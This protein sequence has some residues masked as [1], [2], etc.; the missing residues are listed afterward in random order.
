MEKV[1]LYLFGAPHI[2]ADG[3][4]VKISRRKALALL[5]Y[6]AAN[7]RAHSRESLAA[8]L[9]PEWDTASARTALRRVLV[10]AHKAVGPDALRVEQDRISLPAEAGLW[11]DVRRF[12]AAL[13]QSRA[14][15]HSHPHTCTDC[16]GWLREAAELYRDDFLAGFGLEDTSEFDNWQTFEAESLRRDAGEVLEKLASIYAARRDYAQAIGF[17]RRWLALDPLHEPAHQMLIRLYAWAGDQAAALRQYGE[18]AQLL[19]RELGVSP[20][21]ETAELYEL[22]KAGKLAAEILPLTAPSPAQSGPAL[23]ATATEQFIRLPRLSDFI[24]RRAELT[25]LCASLA[26]PNQRLVTVLG[27][28]GMGKTSL[29][30]VAAA[31]ATDSFPDGVAFV[32]LAPLSHP[33][34]IVPTIAEAIHYNFPPDNR[35]PLEQLVGYLSTRRLLLVLDNFEHLLAGAEIVAGLLQGAPK[36]SLLVTSRERLNLRAEIVFALDGM[37]ASDEE[38]LRLFAQSARRVQNGYTPQPGEMGSIVEICRLVGGMPLGIVMAAGWM[39][40]L[41]PQ[42]IAAEIRNS[43]DVL[44]T[45]LRDIPARQQSMRAV[46]E[47][48]WARLSDAER[49]TLMRLSVFRRGFTR[50]AAQAVTGASLRSLLA[51]SNRQLIQRTADG[52]YD[53]HEILRQFA[54]ERLGETG[55]SEAAAEAHG[56]HFIQLLERSE[57]KLKGAGQMGALDRLRAEQEN[58]RTAWVWALKHRQADDLKQAV[59]AYSLFYFLRGRPHEGVEFCQLTDA[60]FAQSAPASAAYARLLVWYGRFNETFGLGAESKRMYQRSLKILA[61]LGA[62]GRGVRR[63]RAFALCE[64]GGIVWY[65]DIAGARKL[66]VESIELNRAVGD[67]WQLAEAL[68]EFA[69]LLLMEGDYHTCEELALEGLSIRKEIGDRLQTPSPLAILCWA[70]LNQDRPEQAMTYAQEQIRIGEE[71]TSPVIVSHGQFNIGNVHTHRGEYDKAKRV[72]TNALKIAEGHGL[73][74]HANS[75]RWQLCDIYTHSGHYQPACELAQKTIAEADAISL[76]NHRGHALRF[77]GMALT[78][79]E[80]HSEARQTIEESVEIFQTIHQPRFI[81]RVQAALAYAC[82]RADHIPKAI[83]SL[84]DGLEWALEHREIETLAAGLPLAALL[85]ADEGQPERAIE[86]HALTWRYPRIANSRWF[87]D[88]AGKELEALAR[89]LPSEVAAAAQERGRAL[90]LFATAQGLVERFTEKR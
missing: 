10:T 53:I 25:A 17:A 11:V 3:A 12:R 7:E 61:E 83:L 88:V 18:C 70:V 63:E 1:C 54:G 24:G 90:D 66:L 71:N 60:H 49:D 8:L 68:R 58:V 87:Y 74:H 79:L 82:Y 75:C 57:T 52:R 6:L 5:A 43:L 16:L 26:D 21:S 45:E 36:V 30:V 55:L 22:V 42:E 85:M 78:A 27:M 84:T 46:M 37:A 14:H 34:A 39:E 33:S 77:L 31:H 44:A 38:G 13:A 64:L 41:T 72:L 81:V 28:G 4:S 48:T 86:L 50:E 76:R 47:Q 69:R 89:S 9:W 19:Q 32:S 23:V 2:E 59:E 80:R 67:R 20:Q 29:A 65:E 62:D 56:T 35:P 40:M 15:R 73:R 51:L